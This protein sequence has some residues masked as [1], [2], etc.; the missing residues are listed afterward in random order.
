MNAIDNDGLKALMM[1]AVYGH[2]YIVQ[3]LLE[4]GA[5]VN[6]KNNAGDTTPIAVAPAGQNTSKLPTIRRFD[7]WR[8]SI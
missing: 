4:K 8:S 1:A 3:A 2:I 6:A 5:N 7:I